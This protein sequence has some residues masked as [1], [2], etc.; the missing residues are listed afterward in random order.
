MGGRGR[1]RKQL[2]DVYKEK[3]GFCKFTEEALYGKIAVEEDMDP[4]KTYNKMNE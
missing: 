1:R 4:C 2:L 3:R